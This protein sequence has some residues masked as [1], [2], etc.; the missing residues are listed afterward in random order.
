LGPCGPWVNTGKSVTLRSLLPGTIVTVRVSACHPEFGINTVTVWSPSVSETLI[1]VV[2][3]VDAPSTTTWAP[4]G[5]D[6][7]FRLPFAASTLA[8]PQTR[9]V[10][11]ARRTARRTSFMSISG[12]F[13][14]VRENRLGSGL[15]DR[16]RELGGGVAALLLLVAI[17][18]VVISFPIPVALPL[19]P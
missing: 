4:D 13:R 5:K 18:F 16:L 2:F 1:G 8:V 10:I 14:G 7:T 17:V 15:L 6:V 3:P 9:R 19:L 12:P 11:A